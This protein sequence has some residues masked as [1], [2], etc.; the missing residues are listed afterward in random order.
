MQPAVGSWRLLS[1]RGGS[2][3]D[4]VVRGGWQAV[5]RRHC[6]ETVKSYDFVPLSFLL[7]KGIG[8]SS[9]ILIDCK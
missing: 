1:N 7:R 6:V 2:D 3:V 5:H 9:T 8:L 4:A